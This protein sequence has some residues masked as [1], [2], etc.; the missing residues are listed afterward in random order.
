MNRRRH[1]SAPSLNSAEG[2]FYKYG[3]YGI[4]KLDNELVMRMKYFRLE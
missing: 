1:L 2:N 4:I 3:K